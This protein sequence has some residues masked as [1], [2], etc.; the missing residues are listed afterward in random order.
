ME[1][2]GYFLKASTRARRPLSRA[3]PA[4]ALPS[5][6]GASAAGRG[7][8]AAGGADPR[9]AD[10]EEDASQLVFPKGGRPAGPG[11]REGRREGGGGGGGEGGGE[12]PAVNFILFFQEIILCKPTPELYL[13]LKVRGSGVCVWG[14]I[15][16]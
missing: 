11:G 4:A 1:L 7:A 6:A 8:M 2:S 10:V 15:S 14:G 12:P 3:R 5:A 9:T 13:L 16:S